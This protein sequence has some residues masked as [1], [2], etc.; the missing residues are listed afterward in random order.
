[1]ARKKRP[2]EPEPTEEDDG[3]CTVCN[4][5]RPICESGL[6]DGTPCELHRLLGSTCSEECAAKQLAASQSDSGTADGAERW[7]KAGAVLLDD[8]P[9][10]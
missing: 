10:E 3:L 8:V 7:L 6:P 9:L 4:E 5:L 1:M 2:P